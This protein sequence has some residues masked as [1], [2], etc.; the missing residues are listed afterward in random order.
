[1]KFKTHND[2]TINTN[3]TSLVGSMD[4]SYRQLV[5]IFGEPTTGDEYKTD[6]EWEIQF[7]DGT[8][9]TIY[10]YKSGKNYNGAEGQATS[11][12]RDWHIGGHNQDA[13]NRVIEVV[14]EYRDAHDNKGKFSAEKDFH[15]N[16]ISIK[17]S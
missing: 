7:E 4:I 14:I 13:Y 12:I 6:A 2:E 8:I 17:T 10:N 5:H 3:G 15:K 11:R 9:A 16:L 1:M